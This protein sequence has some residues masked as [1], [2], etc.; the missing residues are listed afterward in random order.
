MRPLRVNPRLW[1][2]FWLALAS[3]CISCSG[4]DDAAQGN[5]PGSQH[6]EDAASTASGAVDDDRPA[7]DSNDLNALVDL[8]VA[9]AADIPR[10]E[11]QPSVLAQS[12]GK[13]PAVHVEWVR[14]HTWWVPYRGLLR[15]SQG[16]LLD[17]VGSNLDRSVLLADL[18]RNAGHSVRLAHAQLPEAQARELLESTK[19]LPEQRLTP[20]KRKPRSIER[21]KASAAILPDLDVLVDRQAAAATRLSKEAREL[22][23][24]QT[25]LLAT[26]I[27]RPAAVGGE[28]ERIAVAAMRDYWWVEHEKDGNWIA[29]DVHR[30]D[31]AQATGLV[32]ASE[33]FAWKGDQ[34]S[35]SLPDSN[36]HTVQV[37]VIVERSEAG[38]TS[39]FVVLETKL[40]PAEV[41]GRP[42]S[43]MHMPSPWPERTGRADPGALKNA[44]LWVSEWVPFLQIG[45][46]FVVQSGFTE[47]GELKRNP[48][49]PLGELGG[50]GL[51]GGMDQALGGAED[52]ESTATAEWIEYEIQVPNEPT[53]K[54]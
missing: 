21:E 34:S 4:K 11:F 6:A 39:E 10:V 52:V 27:T 13:D 50:G 51:L 17:R 29:L 26:A 1:L 7:V 14:N 31:G 19:H 36:W 2:G 45:D 25:S 42:T 46:D 8:V 44:A 40:R 12:L 35:P 23:G 48:I 32:P 41:L 24:S 18:L 5:S 15:G 43:L 37:R 3:T 28:A 53:R 49:A 47:R 16:V 54:I 38:T 33:T 30:P 20:P 9:D 22:V